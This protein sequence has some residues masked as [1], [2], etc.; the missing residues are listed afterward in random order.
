MI[1]GSSDRYCPGCQVLTVFWGLEFINL[2]KTP[3]YGGV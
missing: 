1:P 2:N 3:I